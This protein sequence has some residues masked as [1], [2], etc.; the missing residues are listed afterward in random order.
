M[1]SLERANVADRHTRAR[2]VRGVLKLVKAA[3]RDKRGCAFTKRVQKKD[4]LH[5]DPPLAK[6]REVRKSRLKHRP[7]QVN[8]REGN[9]KEKNYQDESLLRE[10]RIVARD[11]FQGKEL[12]D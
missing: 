12:S 4:Q 8:K 2:N 5:P 3:K 1:T 11:A 6:R 7:L 10:P 9:R